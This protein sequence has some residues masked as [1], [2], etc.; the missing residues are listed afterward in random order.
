[1]LVILAVAAAGAL[2]ALMLHAGEPSDLWWS[3]LALPFGAWII[4]PAVTP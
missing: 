3:L 2:I 1:M 4:G